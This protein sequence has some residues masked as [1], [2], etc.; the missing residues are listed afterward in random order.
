MKA[1][2]M[3]PRHTAHIRGRPQDLPEY[4]RAANST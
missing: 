4:Q 3:P 2:A 1:D